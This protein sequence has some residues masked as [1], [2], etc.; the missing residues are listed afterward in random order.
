MQLF[1]KKQL[2]RFKYIGLSIILVFSLVFLMVKFLEGDDLTDQKILLLTQNSLSEKNLD[3][4]EEFS[5]S[6]AS[7][8]KSKE[9]N[10]EL[11]GG[12]S[13]AEIHEIEN[14]ESERDYVYEV[15][16]VYQT[17]DDAT[18]FKLAEEGDQYALE[19]GFNRKARLGDEA[20]GY[21][22]LHQAA[23]M[24]STTALITMGLWME[25][26]L[27]SIKTHGKSPDALVEFF[28]L[29]ENPNSIEETL[30]N[31]A[32]S[33]YVTG[34]LRGNFDSSLQHINSLQQRVLKRK[35][36]QEE[37]RNMMLNAEDIFNRLQ[38]IRWGMGRGDF[39]NQYPRSYARFYGLPENYTGLHDLLKESAR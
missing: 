29:N 20:D 14:W 25:T 35:I 5:L 23:A 6:G 21:K 8:F 2:F 22:M 12:L 15:R 19:E 10:V 38:A 16:Q 18:I 13:P 34:M 33:Y 30:I 7:I 36:T 26:Q 32:G 27:D 1:I 9:N 28:H 39:D 31:L 4:S 11:A 24:G 17:Y 37:W 3:G